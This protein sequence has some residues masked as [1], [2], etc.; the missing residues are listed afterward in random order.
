MYERLDACP[1][2]TKTQLTNL[3]VVED[4]SISGESFVIV[5]CDNCRF[6]FTNPRPTAAQLPSYY[7][8]PNYI[9]H[10]SSS[11]S[12]MDLAYKAVRHYMLRKKLSWINRLV[13]TKGTLLD[14]G[15]GTGSFLSVCQNAGWQVTGV[16][17]NDKARA[18]AI[19]NQLSIFQGYQQ[20]NF[21]RQFDIISLWHVLEHVGDLNEVLSDLKKLLASKGYLILALP[22][23]LSFDA[24]YYD[25][26]WAGYDV[27]RH[28]Y[29]FAPQDVKNLARKHQLKIQETIPLKLDAYYVSLLSAKYQKQSAISAIKTAYR[30]NQKAQQNNQYSSLVY[31][32]KK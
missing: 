14:Y 5:Q 17:P 25:N 10:S 3:K 20:E 8:S 30:S 22:N 32:L 19:Q 9:S 29:H 16:E 1:I 6:C 23:H 7:E 4:H 11:R 21:P 18:V 2:C 13:P 15:C 27:P 24:E 31:I 28:L 26:H 12:I